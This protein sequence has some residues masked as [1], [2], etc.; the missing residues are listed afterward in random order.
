MV[1]NLVALMRASSRSLLESFL[2]GLLVKVVPSVDLEISID[3]GHL[4]LDKI[5]VA[6]DDEL[7]SVVRVVVWGVHEEAELGHLSAIGFLVL[8]IVD[9]PSVR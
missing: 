5:L 3:L 2:D 8:K 4:R 7:L 6:S 1:S 9:S